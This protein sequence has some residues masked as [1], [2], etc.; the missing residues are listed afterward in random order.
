MPST[1]KSPEVQFYDMDDETAS[2]QES[3]DNNIPLI[4]AHFWNVQY[5]LQVPGA[6]IAAS[7]L[8]PA[9][10]AEVFAETKP[11]FEAPSSYSPPGLSEFPSRLSVPPISP[12]DGKPSSLRPFCSQLNNQI[13]SHNHLFPSEISKVRFAYQCLG[14]GA[15]IKMRSCFRCLEDPSA[16][17]EI[18]TMNEF[19]AALRQQCQDP[20]L[21]DKATRAVETMTQRN[22]KFQD[23]ITLFE[24]NIVDSTYGLSEKGVWKKM[25]ERRLSY[26]LRDILLSASDAPTEYHAFVTY[27]RKKDA[28]IQ[29]MRAAFPSTSTPTST[30]APTPNWLPQREKSPTSFRPMNQG[31]SIS[32]WSQRAN[33]LTTSQGGTA[34]DLDAISREKGPDGRLTPQAKDAR[35]SLGRCFRCNTKGHLALNC[36]L[37]NSGISV[38]TAES[39]SEGSEL[40][41]G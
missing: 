11:K 17:P 39:I 4:P 19:M 37:N 13:Q 31:Q 32:P 27:L 35:R 23:F 7:S 28:G 9:R 15:L 21:E 1:F 30:F 2:R 8:D 5:L 29:E 33:E 34:M 12:Y 38:S 24:D 20:G 10:V 25:L 6:L 40:L 3:P 36:S 26:K 18:T 22:M 41:K 14:P 16:P